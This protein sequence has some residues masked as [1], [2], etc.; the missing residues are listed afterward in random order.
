[1]RVASSFLVI[2]F[3]SLGAG[4]G[5]G[6][7]HSGQIT[8]GVSPNATT[9]SAASSVILTGSAAGFDANPVLEWWVQESRDIDP[10]NDCG[11][12]YTQVP[13]QSGCPYGYVVY[14]PNQGLPSSATYFAPATPGTYHVTFTASEWAQSGHVIKNVEATITV[15]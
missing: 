3:L 9:I 6:V 7:P 2:C 13:P 11:F 14:D 8:M 5:N 12:L 15:Q 10:A 4:C 1:M